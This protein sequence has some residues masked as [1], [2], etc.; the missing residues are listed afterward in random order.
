MPGRR[1]TIALSVIALAAAAYAGT[2]VLL[3]RFQERI[4]FQPPDSL[5]AGESV[6]REVGTS[7]LSCSTTDGLALSGFVVAG[8]K[9]GPIIL[10]FHG[11]AVTARQMIPW[12][13]EVS[14][15][16]GVTVVLPE[17]RGYDGM[18]GVPTYE[19]ARRDAAAALAAMVDRFHVP[20]GNLFYYGHSLGT[21]VATE[22]AA[23]DPPRALIL[24]SPFTSARDMAAR[25]PVVGL[26][27]F[28]RAISRVHYATVERV[29]SLDV[30]VSVAHGE[31]DVIVPAR[32]GTAVYAAARRKGEL[33]VVPEAGHNDVAAVGGDDYW[34]WLARAVGAGRQ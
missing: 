13:E 1:V 4:V 8:P 5:P 28:W 10:A 19:G 32:M 16:L 23:E 22:L 14:R 21:A 34:R 3:W 30:P 20:P 27:C 15:R 25:M 12:A 7:R 6:S 11:N 9:D 29:A 18:A 26:T 33:L 2:L 17:Y 24:E 31:R